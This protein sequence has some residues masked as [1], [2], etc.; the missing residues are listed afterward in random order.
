MLDKKAYTEVFY[1]INELSE[2]LRSKIPSE[3]IK[4]IENKMDRNY[5]F[6]IEDDIENAELLEDTEKILSVLYTDYFAT[7]E[8]RELIKNKEKILKEKQKS[9]LPKVKINEIF[10]RNKEVKIEEEKINLLTEIPK[11]KWYSRLLNVFRKFWGNLR[12][13]R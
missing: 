2:E 12:N 7:N 9:D 10:P 8:E 1:I 11:E 4:N 5:D 13:R 3:I 6:N